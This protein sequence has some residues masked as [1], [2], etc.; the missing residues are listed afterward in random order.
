MNKTTHILPTANKFFNSGFPGKSYSGYKIFQHLNPEVAGFFEVNLAVL[1]NRFPHFIDSNE[2]TIK[3]SLPNPKKDALNF[4]VNVVEPCATDIRVEIILSKDKSYALLVHFKPE[5]GSSSERAL[6][7]FLIESRFFDKIYYEK[8]YLDKSCN[9]IDALEHYVKHGN[10]SGNYCGVY[11]SEDKSVSAETGLIV[12][13]TSYGKRV[14]T[15]HH[16]IASLLNQSIENY[17]IILWLS[18]EEFPGK[19]SDLPSE[20]VKLVGSSFEVKWTNDIKSYKKI[21]PTLTRYPDATIVTADDDILYEVDWLE[22]LYVEHIRYPEHI[23]AHR[24]HRINLD[25]NGQIL[26]Y[27][28]WEKRTE[29]HSASYLNFFTGA[30]GVLYPPRSLYKDVV[31]EDKFMSLSPNADDIWLWIMCL[32]N[33]R[34]VL[35]PRNVKKKLTYLDGTQDITDSESTPLHFENVTNGGNDEKLAR[36]IAEYPKVNKIIEKRALSENRKSIVFICDNNYSMITSVAIASLMESK[37]TDTQ[38]HVYVILDGEVDKTV[39]KSVEKKYR[40]SINYIENT[41]FS[42]RGIHKYQKDS[43]CVASESALLKFKID[44]LLENED[45]VLYL[46]GDILVRKDLSSVFETNISGKPLAAVLDTGVLYNKRIQNYSKRY[47]NSG[48]MLL[49]LYEFR[50]NAYSEALVKVKSE[51]NDYSLMD[52]NVFNA[53]F[54]DNF[55]ELPIKYNFLYTN[56]IRAGLKYDIDDINKLFDTD[57][58][59]LED[60]L[61]V[62]AVVHFASKDKP[63]KFENVPFSRDWYA[64]YKSLPIK[65]VLP[66]RVVNENWPNKAAGICDNRASATNILEL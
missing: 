56:L 38:Y 51:L 63:W 47:F 65:H 59:D 11:T 24:V 46:D 50:K 40:F 57:Y 26:P 34:K 43:Y 39:F 61:G 22:S 33:D 29:K 48:V 28:N 1:N 15:V 52:Q 42:L 62:A 20:L 19:L 66:N 45:K 18:E 53:V 10:A 44:Y 36:A 30:G 25:E 35:V 49:N 4:F 31:N 6:R 7:D 12:S 41:D 3:L 60:V 27:H 16:V 5:N 17:R 32:M 54:K 9:E 37:F 58:K 2:I 14:K 64:I 55:V 13:L 8:L 21:I 23:V